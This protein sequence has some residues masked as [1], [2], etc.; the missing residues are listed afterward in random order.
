MDVELL[1]VLDRPNEARAELPVRISLSMTSV[2]LASYQ[3]KT[4]IRERV[5]RQGDPRDPPVVRAGHQV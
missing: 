4:L 1:V 5:V 2:C 3:P